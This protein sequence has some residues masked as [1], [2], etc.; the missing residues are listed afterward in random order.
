VYLYVEQVDDW[1]DDLRRAGV[2]LEGEPEDQ[3]WGNREMRLRDPFG[4]RLCIATV[5]PG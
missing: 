4:N 2:E 5:L 3:P 1:C